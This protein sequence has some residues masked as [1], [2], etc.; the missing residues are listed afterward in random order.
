MRAALERRAQAR[1]ATV[2]EEIATALAQAGVETR[3]EGDTVRLSGCGLRARW[4][5]D[6][7]LREAGRNRR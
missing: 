4:A 6:L 5:G 2:R 1:A 7:A 3:I